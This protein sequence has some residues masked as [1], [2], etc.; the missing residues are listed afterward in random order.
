MS[1]GVPDGPAAHVGA[2]AVAGVVSAVCSTPVDV[3][4]TRLM[5]QAGGATASG[6]VEYAGV[7]D[8]FTRMPRLEGVS[9]LYKGFVPMAARKVGWTV[10][11]FI[12]YE[13]AL[14][15]VKGSYS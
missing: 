9:A 10:A 7:L 5:A 14:K 2:S 1:V 4:K 3:V 12:V 6:V 15:L 13:Q 8:C 11:Y